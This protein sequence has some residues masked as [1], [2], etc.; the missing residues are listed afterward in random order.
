MMRRLVP[1]LLA[2]VFYVTLTVVFTWPL[3]ARLSDVLAS[4]L[5]D[6]ILNTW[7]IWWNAH[8][9]PLSARWWDAPMF[10]PSAGA[11]AFS[12]TLLG[13][14]PFTT[15]IQWLGGSPS[16]AYNVAFFL[17][18]PLSAL[19]THALVFRLTRRHDAAL[20]GGLI[21]GFHPFRVAH[22]PQIQVM[23]SYWMPASLLGLHAYLE[24]RR[25]Q[26]LWLSAGAWLM[27]A[28]SNGYYLLFFPVLAGLWIVW[29]T[30][31]P[32][33]IRTTA[34][35][36]GA[37]AVASI[38]L[39]PLLWGYRRIH[40][41]Y[42]FQRDLGEVNFF[43]ADVTSLLDISPLS[44]FWNLHAF[45]QA[46]GELF[47]GLTASLLVLLVIIQW[48]WRSE[49]DKR[50]PRTCL[51]LLV[52]AIAFIG[53]ALSAMLLGPWTITVGGV[54]LVSV[55]V[56]SKPLSIG[57][58]LFIAAL[59]L[60][61]RFVGTLRRRSA[62][63]FYTLATATMYL[64]CFGPQPRFL[65]VPFM[66][67][68]P[69]SWLMALP[70]YDAVR[71]PARFAMLAALCLSIAA[72]LAFVRLTSRARWSSRATLAGIV[73][74]GVLID[75]WISKMPLPPLPARLQALESQST[76]P[77]LELPL[78][79]TGD[80]VGAM[81][82]SMYHGRPVVNGYSGFFPA[83]YNA[84]QRG[85]TMGDPQMFDAIAGWG[86]VTVAVDRNR[87][88]GGRWVSQLASRGETVDLGEEANW[89]FFLLNGG[90]LLRDG[91]LPSYEVRPSDR[92]EIQSLSANVNNRRIALALDG[93]PATRWDSGPQQGRE[94][95]VVDLGSTRTI[96]A[97]T[98][99]ITGHLSDFPRMLVVETSDDGEGWT[100]QWKGTTGVL[101]FAGA[102]RNPRQIPLTIPLPSVSARLLRLRQLGHDPVFYW[103]I[104]ELEVFGR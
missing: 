85:F 76:T 65:G 49:R 16:T 78:G 22:F 100:E 10:W 89:K 52:A 93:D 68:A 51:V 62:L 11:L 72:A 50:A 23:T 48:L 43:G 56:V 28:L 70:G 36:L 73:V 18:F 81:Y 57:V 3:V 80:D 27:Q 97:V 37:W 94:I 2:A 88:A 77:V 74:A 38:P 21:Y 104:A 19:A 29:F 15:P 58:L 60:E 71:V 92:L 64:L 59:A 25:R 61:P 87:D 13:L 98:M 35:I 102:I 14:A 26:W 8:A 63:M 42:G 1:W 103:T 6:P 33:R 99:T 34:A 12:E 75:S 31:S 46:E 69:Y 95:V 101:A 40:D 86:S 24:S 17:T 91:S 54:T 9:V 4:D 47:P 41:A 53:V 20:I 67:R 83:S 79:E 84:L 5:G 82:R 30:L 96:R 90:S 44:K 55:R 45:H 32:S 66:Y 7:I 39:V